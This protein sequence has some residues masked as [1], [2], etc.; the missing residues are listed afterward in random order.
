MKYSLAMIIMIEKNSADLVNPPEN[1]SSR[2]YV[3]NMMNTQNYIRKVLMNQM[4]FGE[5]WR[6]I[7]IGLK[8]GS[9]LFQL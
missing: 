2:A 5:K 4:L 1:V 9:V 8:V 6:K 7:F 3:G